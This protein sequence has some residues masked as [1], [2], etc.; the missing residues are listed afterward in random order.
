MSL[1]DLAV[2]FEEGVIE[3]GAVVERDG[4]G[5]VFGGAGGIIA[6][7]FE[8]FSLRIDVVI[9][10]ALTGFEH[11]YRSTIYITDHCDSTTRWS[12]CFDLARSHRTVP[13]LGGL[14]CATSIGIC[15]FE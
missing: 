11:S 8:I 15:V 9:V 5:R 6:E 14:H 1:P 3:R 12:A 10:A 4:C 7:S 2:F 13:S